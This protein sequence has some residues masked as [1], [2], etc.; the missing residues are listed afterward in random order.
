MGLV[1]GRNND[2]ENGSA[3][4]NEKLFQIQTEMNMDLFFPIPW[5]Y[6]VNNLNDK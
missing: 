1:K 2:Q 5:L 4:Y 6:K 3:V